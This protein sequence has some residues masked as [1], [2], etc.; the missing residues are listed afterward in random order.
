MMRELNIF[1]EAGAMGIPGAILEICNEQ[2]TDKKKVRKIRN[3]CEIGL[4]LQ[5]G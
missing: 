5:R 3:F 4:G 1:L 2:L